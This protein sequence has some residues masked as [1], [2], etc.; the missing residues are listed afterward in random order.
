VGE[1]CSEAEEV[2]E[3]VGKERGAGKVIWKVPSV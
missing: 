1:E 2:A 3:E